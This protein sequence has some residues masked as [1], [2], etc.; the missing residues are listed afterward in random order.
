MIPVSNIPNK[1]GNFIL[2]KIPPEAIPNKKIKAKLV[3][4][5]LPYPFSNILSLLIIHYV[6]LF[7]VLLKFFVV[8][9]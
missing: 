1:L 6:V 5:F 7:I 8:N 9:K 3:N 4:I 2:L